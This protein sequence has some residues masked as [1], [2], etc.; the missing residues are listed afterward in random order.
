MS[1]FGFGTRSGL[2]RASGSRNDP[3]ITISAFAIS[4][5]ALP[6][7]TVG[8]LSVTAGSGAYT[9]SIPASGNPD[10][11]FA[12]SGDGLVTTGP[13]DFETAAFHQV[14]IEADN[15]VDPVLSRTLTLSVTN[16]F[17]QPSLG[18]LSLSGSVVQGSS[19][20]ISGAT[21]GS[22][23]VAPILPDGWTLDGPSREISIANDAPLGSQD[24][25]LLE[26]LSDSANS[27]NA[28]N[29]TSLVESSTPSP[30]PFP[31][32]A[33][34][35]LWDGGAGSG[36]NSAPSDPSRI[37]AKPALRLIEPPHQH[38]TDTLT[39]G[40][41]AMA[42]NEGT[43][44][45]GVSAVRFYFESDTPVEVASPTFRTL[46]R[47]DGSTYE[48]LGYWVDLKKSA[49]VE[50]VARL[51]IEATPADSTMQN[52]VIGPFLY[53]PV[54]T[55]HDFTATV[56]AA[57]DYAD[58]NAAKEAARNSGAANPLIEL[59]DDGDYP[60]AQGGP[61]FIP[62][63][64]LTVRPSEGV[65]ARFTLGAGNEAV[66]NQNIGRLW[67]EEIAIDLDTI[68]AIKTQGD[69]GQVLKRCRAERTGGRQL[70]FKNTPP[71]S[72][73]VE[74]PAYL[75]ECYTDGVYEIGDANALMRG[76]INQRGFGD[77][78]SSC[79]A[80]L[81]NTFDDWD[82]LD[83]APT[84]LG[85]MTIAYS[86]SGSSVTLS[87]SFQNLGP[88]TD[89]YRVF[90]LKVDNATVLTFEAW[91]FWDRYDEP[92]TGDGG[93]PA[94]V[95]GYEVQHF[96]D[97][98]NA[99][100]NFN[101]TLLNNDVAARA[102]N[103]QGSDDNAD[104]GDT[105]I[106][107]GAGSYDVI[108]DLD[109]HAGA[110]SGN[111]GENR[112]HLFDEITDFND[113]L[114]WNYSQNPGYND[115]VIAGCVIG[116]GGDPV[117]GSNN[118]IAD[119]YSHVVFIHNSVR[120]QNVFLGKSNGTTTWDSYCL[121]SNNASPTL[122]DNSNTN[123]V[124]GANNHLE[125]ATIVSSNFS[126]TLV[127]GSTATWFPNADS[128]D[129]APAGE[130]LASP[131]PPVMVYDKDGTTR[132]NPSPVGASSLAIGSSEK[133]LVVIG[134]LGQSNMAGFAP[135]GPQDVDVPGIF[136]FG[137]QVLD[138]ATYEQITSDITPLLHPRNAD[139]FADPSKQL[140]PG[141]YIARQLKTNGYIP[142]GYDVLIVPCA[143]GGTSLTVGDEEWKPTAPLGELM[144]NAID[145]CTNAVAAAQAVDS[146]SYFA[147]FA[148]G[149]GENDA[150]ANPSATEGDYLT[151]FNQVVDQIRTNVPTAADC[152]VM[153]TSMPPKFTQD[154]SGAQ[155]IEAAHRRA[156][157][158]GTNIFFTQ[159]PAGLNS[160]SAHYNAAGYRALGVAAADELIARLAEPGVHYDFDGQLL[161]DTKIAGATQR[162][163]TNFT[164]ADGSGSGAPAKSL[165]VSGTS[166]IAS[167]G[168]N[169][170]R[171]EA[172]SGLADVEVEWS[173]NISGTQIVTLRASGSHSATYG[174]DGYLIG[175]DGSG[176]GSVGLFIITGGSS[177]AQQAGSADLGLTGATGR[178]RASVVGSTIKFEV[179][180][181]DGANWTTA[182]THTDTTYM[183]GGDVVYMQGDGAGGT[184]GNEI[185]AYDFLLRNKAAA[186]TLGSLTI[187]ASVQQ[188]QVVAI[189]GAA[190]GSTI[191]GTMP[192]GWTLDGAAR[193]ITIAAD[194][195]LGSQNWA[196]S[197]A[198]SGATN[199]PKPST[200]SATVGAGSGFTF[201][202]SEASTYV[203]AMT[204][205]PSNTIKTAIDQL[206]TDLKAAGVF[207]KMDALWLV[208]AHDDQAARLNLIA[209]ASNTITGTATFA[210]GIGFTGNGTSALDSN[211]DL[212]AGT[213]YT[214]ASASIFAHSPAFNSSNG[215]IFGVTSTSDVIM[216]PILSGGGFF[217][218][219]GDA[220]SG[221]PDFFAGLTTLTYDNGTTRVYNNTTL[222]DTDTRDRRDVTPSGNLM[223]FG[224]NGSFSG[225]TISSAGVGS[226]LSA[227]EIGDLSALL[228]TY[229]ATVENG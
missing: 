179:S 225:Y 11:K 63:G 191:T 214:D 53:Y 75:L 67:L 152:W 85:R 140:G 6:G 205:E 142:S 118:L 207:A 227:T 145:R 17:E 137:G 104:F 222:E 68:A 110:I 192:T 48:C 150:G 162:G 170:L 117:V 146:N 32:V 143:R 213:N 98:I 111:S 132:A 168:T 41:I 45:E 188:G 83:I 1:G 25:L 182:F 43:L 3:R 116:Q 49:G 56:G 120:G 100:P 206:V 38:F 210:A 153:I 126:G 7:S 219:M 133:P 106:I 196:L 86:G 58:F 9:F 4:E 71:D 136:Q 80:T 5:D 129:F 122:G 223:L 199:T 65:S 178:F 88:Q 226:H 99:L 154:R 201:T 109:L 121:F 228:A 209:P 13:L 33:P 26:T 28:S 78:T 144:Q 131:K 52:R 141:D 221:S 64:Y 185:F 40:A 112:I 135:L 39:V 216:Q 70:W 15:G 93:S 151:A 37:T 8:I 16:V 92:V 186:V 23:I 44:I 30:S 31:I 125:Q 181:D 114:L 10:D 87:R 103:L 62:T 19:V 22:T 97:A 96:V 220:V 21:P 59:L 183:A 84:D 108:A 155:A 229:R 89:R 76:T 18:A 208:D 35:P 172:V 34:G 134:L 60:L 149:Q 73:F 29:G 101:A 127:S 139:N 202:N 55:L 173:S 36:F 77:I 81:Y 2:H 79:P 157:L 14:T 184:S 51:F 115:I 138:P 66:W 195:P 94:K 105:E 147:G 180:N 113:S 159:G 46:T 72:Y 50:G 163:A 61:A 200:G 24:W 91:Q 215:P 161:G 148:W 124:Q 107:S 204:V 119:A 198:L 27:P 175:I 165:T 176:N 197:E 158:E 160:D 190:A 169:G 57:G 174:P 90:T 194:A 177:T 47:E 82:W 95:R 42:N 123:Q 167:P 217:G 69:A 203:A 20:S 224:G 218:R 130:L 171:L 156:A 74:G 54:A 128:G 164:I 12:L 102:L 212:S 166:A 193:T 211:Y 187:P 189:I